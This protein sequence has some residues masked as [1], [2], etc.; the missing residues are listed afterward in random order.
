MPEWIAALARIACPLLLALL[1]LPGVASAA[2]TEFDWRGVGQASL[3]R[4]GGDTDL[5]GAYAITGEGSLTTDSGLGISLTATIGS[6]DYGKSLDRPGR[7]DN[8][9][10]VNELFVT[11][12]SAWGRLRLGDE[13][14][15]A[16]RAVD[17]LPLLAGGQMDGHWVRGAAAP[18]LDHLG[19]DS[20]DATKLLYETPRVM[21]LRL[22][23]SYA[24]K[25]DSLV[26]DIARETPVR[27][28]RDLWE[29]GAN[30]QGDWEAFSYEL[31]AGYAMAE[32]RAPGIADTDSLKLAG[33]VYYGG[34]SGGAVWVDD[35]D[36]GRVRGDKADSLTLMGGYRNGPFGLAL[37]WQG[38]ESD[39][40]GAYDAVGAG[41]S[42]RLFDETSLALDAVRYEGGRDGWTGALTLETRF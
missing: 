42:W 35:G 28:D 4:G 34:F 22:G 12:N 2:T 9:L 33:L 38:A 15:A 23:A 1:S 14:G 32:A 16:K 11:V 19:R 41:L 5:V 36:S 37:W 20:D 21:G 26:E 3:L 27:L 24:W 31:A 25:R 40:T 18:P 7:N 17:L 6:G 10:T 30:Y 8:P 29:F 39:L 13:D